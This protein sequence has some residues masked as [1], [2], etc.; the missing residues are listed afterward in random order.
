MVASMTS[1]LLL[2]FLAEVFIAPQIIPDSIRPPGPPLVLSSV[3]DVAWSC[4]MVTITGETFALRGKLSGPV[5]TDDKLRR[6]VTVD[7]E[8]PM[9]VSGRGYVQW[10]GQPNGWVIYDIG[11]NSTVY[12]LTMN[13]LVEGSEDGQ[14]VVEV[15]EKIAGGGHTSWRHY[16][17]GRCA[18]VLQPN[19]RSAQ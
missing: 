9:A 12:R 16:A 4:S 7:G 18:T 17:I 19:D 5:K 15:T 11:T 8:S 2:P 6:E 1:I 3:K 14:V 13:E 10:S